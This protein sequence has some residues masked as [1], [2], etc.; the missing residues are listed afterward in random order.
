[1]CQIQ[2]NVF[3]KKKRKINL[4]GNQIQIYQRPNFSDKRYYIHLPI[5]FD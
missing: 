1:M 5:V 4:D 2:N 3:E